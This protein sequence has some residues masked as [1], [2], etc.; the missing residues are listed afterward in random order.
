MY[1]VWPNIELEKDYMKVKLKTL[2]HSCHRTWKAWQGSQQHFTVSAQETTFISRNL[3]SG[4]PSDELTAWCLEDYK[5]QVSLICRE[6]ALI[7][8]MNTNH[9][10]RNGRCRQAVVQTENT[11]SL[12]NFTTNLLPALGKPNS[13]NMGN[14]LW[15]NLIR[16]YVL[17]LKGSNGRTNF[18]QQKSFES[19]QERARQQC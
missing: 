4:Y 3:S 19:N 16:A 14:D 8:S 7:T 6:R 18:S 13:H 1:F 11:Q 12:V 9:V 10:N 17:A 15:R 2:L 5:V